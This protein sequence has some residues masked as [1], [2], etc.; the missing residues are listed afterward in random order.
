MPTEI[1]LQPLTPAEDEKASGSRKSF[2]TACKDVRRENPTLSSLLV[3]VPCGFY[4]HFAGLPD[5]QIF[6]LTFMGILPLAWLIGKTT[7]D[8]ASHTNQV[9]G[10][11]V[12]A[13]FGNVV[14]ML[15]CCA[16][17]I[18]GEITVVQCTLL[19]SIL[20]NLLLVMGT[21]FVYGGIYHKR[22]F[23]NQE[24]AKVQSS[25]LLV[26]LLTLALPMMYDTLSSEDA[27]SQAEVL[28]MSRH[29]SILMLVVYFQYLYFQIIS[30][31]ELFDGGEDGE[32]E[33]VDF[34]FWSAMSVL[35][36][37]TI[38]TAFLSDYLIQS[39]EPAVV[40]FGTSK[41]FIGIIILPIIGN[42]AEHYTA[43]IMAGKNKMDLSLG[44]A[45]GSGCQMMLLVTPLSVLAGW[46]ADKPMSLNFHPFAIAVLLVTI[47]IVNT[48]LANGE[49]NWLEG[50]MLL[51]AYIF[52]AM[53]Y[54]SK[55]A[56]SVYER[57]THVKDL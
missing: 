30:H 53:M 23:F 47:L 51:N 42:A 46:Y 7:E 12:N 56:D 45:V 2:W 34:G 14:E 57:N 40:S 9:L 11:L 26:A 22:Q 35:G 3:F 50:V 10:G 29:G 27:T 4:A 48:I 43:I 31:Q 17:I 1:E 13:T 54:F 15:L 36:A 32:E 38:A 5:W 55:D 20:S 18:H 44:V 8:L 16:G 19:G 39:I 28:S 33:E 25:L 49:T 52:I 21:S 37:A 41:E 6:S 24:G